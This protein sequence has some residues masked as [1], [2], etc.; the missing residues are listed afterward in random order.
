MVALEGGICGE[1]GSECRGGVVGGVGRGLIKA[2]VTKW[3]GVVS[4]GAGS[5]ELAGRAE[6]VK[7]ISVGES[8]RW[9]GRGGVGVG[10]ARHGGTVRWLSSGG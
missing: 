1:V 9:C 10:T 2:E 3:V 6:G 7:N 8:E 5:S 4:K